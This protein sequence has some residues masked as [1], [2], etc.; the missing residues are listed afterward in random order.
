[1]R[2]RSDSPNR[3][4]SEP[5]STTKKRFVIFK[6]TRDDTRFVYFG[7]KFPLIRTR[8]LSIRMEMFD[9]GREDDGRHT[10]YRGAS[11]AQTAFHQHGLLLNPFAVM[12][13]R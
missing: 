1:M 2:R 13:M 4:K 10:E 8:V 11:F 12:L 7:I 9:R 3:S 6:K 5:S